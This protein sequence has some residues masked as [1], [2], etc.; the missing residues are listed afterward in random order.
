MDLYQVYTNYTP[1]AKNGPAAGVTLANIKS[2]F[3]EYGHVAY[4]MKGNEA[5]NNMLNSLPVHTPLT[6]GVG[7]K[8]QFVFFSESSCCMSN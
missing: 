2:T 6:P 8:G 3:S 1:G 5:Y 4:Q 7:S